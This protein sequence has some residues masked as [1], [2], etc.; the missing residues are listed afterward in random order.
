MVVIIVDHLVTFQLLVRIATFVVLL[1]LLSSPLCIVPSLRAREKDSS[2]I[3][4]SLI[5]EGQR[6]DQEMEVHDT[7]DSLEEDNLNLL[8]AMGSVNFW[9]L[10]FA[11]ACGM[12]SGLATV[13]NLGQIG[14]SLGYSN[15]ETNTLVSLWSIWNFLGRFGVGYVSDH[16]LYVKG[17]ARPLFMVLT[18]SSMSVGHAVIASGMPGALY[19]GSILVGVCY[20]SQWSLMPTIAS[21]IFGVKH[22]G[23]IFNAITIASPVGSYLFSVRVVGFIYDKEAWGS[24]CS[25]THCFMLSFLIMASATLLGSLA[26]LA[27]FFHT[28]NFYNQVILRRLLH[29][30]RE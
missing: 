21:E 17:W 16:F 11:M 26:A 23:T 15:F 19:A 29:S 18:L 12:G 3:H 24:G 9:I 20:G 22:M 7:R 13:N 1:L 27:L 14:E 28:K 25:G 6:F 5:S 10:F 4:Q 30:L 8:Q 2:V